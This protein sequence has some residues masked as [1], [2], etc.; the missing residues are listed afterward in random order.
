MPVEAHLFS[1]M[2]KSI[3]AV[4]FR[5]PAAGRG[6]RAG[7]RIPLRRS[8][9]RISPSKTCERAAPRL[10][11]KK[12]RVQATIAGY[13]TGQGARR[14]SLVLN[15]REIANPRQVEVPAER[16]RHR[17]I[18]HLRRP[19]GLNR[20]EVRI[21]SGDDAFP[22][23][24]R[25]LLLRRPRRPAPASCSFTRQKYAR[26]ALF[27]DGA[28]SA[29]GAALSRSIRPRL[30]RRPTCL[31]PSTHSWCCPTS[32][33]P[34]SSRTAFEKYVRGGGICAGRAGP[35]IGL[36]PHRFPCSTKRSPRR[37]MRRAKGSDF[38]P[39]PSSIRASV[40]RE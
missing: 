28:R 36:C 5:R 6:I 16:P 11:S 37:V 17:R 12:V 2:Q 31:R 13:G 33:V 4:E 22:A 27:P 10:R 19:Y 25:S 18:P 21:D 7:A 30:I 38:R 24:D 8:A 1:D 35:D 29:S 23:D 3:D 9:C 15:G 39:P 34:A 26:A 14:V 32:P 40:D 20:G